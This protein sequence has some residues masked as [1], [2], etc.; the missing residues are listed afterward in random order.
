MVEVVETGDDLVFGQS[1]LG[2]REKQAN[3]TDVAAPCIGV[4]IMKGLA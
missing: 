1:N 4:P 3:H 2:W